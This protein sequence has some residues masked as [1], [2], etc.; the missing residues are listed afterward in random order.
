[1][2]RSRARRV[3]LPNGAA[4]R[5]AAG[6]H[7]GCGV[8]SRRG[9][10]ALLPGRRRPRW[11]SCHDWPPQP[12]SERLDGRRGDEHA[13]GR[14][15]PVRGGRGGAPLVAH[16]REHAHLP[17]AETAPVQQVSLRG[18][19]G[20]RHVLALLH[21]SPIARHPLR[22]Q[23]APELSTWSW[24]KSRGWRT[25]E[26]R[27]DFSLTGSSRMPTA[28]PRPRP[29]R[30]PRSDRWSSGPPQVSS[31]G[32]SAGSLALKPP[33]VSH[34]SPVGKWACTAGGEE[35]GGLAPADSS[36]PPAGALNQSDASEAPPPSRPP[37]PSG[38]SRNGLS[39]LRGHR[40]ALP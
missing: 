30:S 7:L 40:R 6:A 31:R 21:L 24:L 15:V 28:G 26:L 3:R 39:R 34:R 11:E 38:R 17:D 25:E 13:G 9:R 29:S 14:V 23:A 8:K 36:P 32:R 22:D 5:I 12:D 27:R 35:L 4:T 37:A 19:P 2:W 10:R 33:T 1:M 16:T 20:Q 18:P